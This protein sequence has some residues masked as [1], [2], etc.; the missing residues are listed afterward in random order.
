MKKIAIQINKPLR[1][2]PIGTI[3]QIKTD[4]NGTPLERYWRDRLKDANIDGCI[5]IVKKKK[6]KG[7]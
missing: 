3:I 5:K 7:D 2:Y 6:S 1:A 4:K